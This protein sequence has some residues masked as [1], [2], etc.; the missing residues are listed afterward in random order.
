MNAS[1][2]APKGQLV[3]SSNAIGSSDKI[4]NGQVFVLNDKEKNNDD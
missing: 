1:D 4:V 3:A 2:S